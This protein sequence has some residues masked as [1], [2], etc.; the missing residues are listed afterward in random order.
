MTYLAGCPEVTQFAFD[1]E[2][3][4]DI[5][6]WLDLGCLL[7]LLVKFLHPLLH[8][9]HLLVTQPIVNNTTN[10]K[11]ATTHTQQHNKQTETA[12]IG[13][14]TCSQQ[15]ETQT[16]TATQPPLS[17]QRNQHSTG[18][19]TNTPST[20]QPISSNPPHSRQA[21][22]PAAGNITH[23]WHPPAT[24]QQPVI[25]PAASNTRNRLRQYLS[26]TQSTFSRQHDPQP[27]TQET[28]AISSPVFASS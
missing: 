10:A 15:L 2:L 17:P 20:T 5:S 1:Q 14:T 12:S 25:Q 11:S 16:E 26:E 23:S 21:T 19:T 27:A 4:R 6:G 7:A 3:G 8:S 18:N 24:H 28:S 22:H 9:Q 13:S